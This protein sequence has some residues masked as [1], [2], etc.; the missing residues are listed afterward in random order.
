MSESQ[1]IC[2]SSSSYSGV[3]K[4]IYDSSQGN[5][6][7]FDSW[8]DQCL[9]CSILIF[10][11]FIL[12]GSV[13]IVKYITHR[14]RNDL[15]NDQDITAGHFVM[16]FYLFNWILNI[17]NPR[18]GNYSFAFVCALSRLIFHVLFAFQLGCRAAACRAVQ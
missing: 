14:H 3:L 5:E 18:I 13:R 7:R 12:R 11:A 8:S 10:I 16:K 4:N 9:K 17:Y 6:T 1:D 2:S 15:A